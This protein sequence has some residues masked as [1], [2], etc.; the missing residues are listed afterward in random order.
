MLSGRQGRNYRARVYV[1]MFCQGRVYVVTDRDRSGTQ[2]SGL[3][4]CV[5]TLLTTG[6]GRDRVGTSALFHSSGLACGSLQ[7]RECSCQE[8]R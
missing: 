4:M 3:R 7:Q 5:S 8:A 2:A 1:V 6:T